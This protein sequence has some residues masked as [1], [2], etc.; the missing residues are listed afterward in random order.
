M[1]LPPFQWVRLTMWLFLLGILYK[2][3]VLVSYGL[4]GEMCTLPPWIN[5]HVHQSKLKKRDIGRSLNR[6]C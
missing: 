3:F 6:G 5:T 1:V 2:A 4:E